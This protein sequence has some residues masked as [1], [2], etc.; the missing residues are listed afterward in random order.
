MYRSVP[1]SQY[2]ELYGA[3]KTRFL[4]AKGIWIRD[5]YLIP[6][7][8]LSLL[9]T[10][11]RGID[12]ACYTKDTFYEARWKATNES[13]RKTAESFALQTTCLLGKRAS[14]TDRHKAVLARRVIYSLLVIACACVLEDSYGSLAEKVFQTNANLL[15]FPTLNVNKVTPCSAAKK[16]HHISDPK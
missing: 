4:R 13:G 16:N 7:S 8:C 5:S 15:P 12:Q 1:L 11:Y 10:S 6:Q 14:N 9:T 3:A 2:P